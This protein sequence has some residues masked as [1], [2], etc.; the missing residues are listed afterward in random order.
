L[1]RTGEPVG[2]DAYW[3]FIQTGSLAEQAKR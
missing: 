1:A 2:T 3:R